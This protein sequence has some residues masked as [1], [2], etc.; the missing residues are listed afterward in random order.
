MKFKFKKLSLIIMSFLLMISFFN[1][2]DKMEFDIVPLIEFQEYKIYSDNSGLDTAIILTIS[3]QDGDGDIGLSQSDTLAP[4]NSGS[5]YYSNMIVEYYEYN[6]TDSQYT[7]VT[8]NPFSD[9]TI[10]YEYRLPIEISPN[11]N[12]KAIKGKIDLTINDILA[13]S[14]PIKFKI[15]IYDRELHKSNIVESPAINYYP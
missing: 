13:K 10:S 1:C 7:K 8:P 9:D 5:E 12:N 3:F 2:S 11:K 14:N 15:Y 6:Y 4:F